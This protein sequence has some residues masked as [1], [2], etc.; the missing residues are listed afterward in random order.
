[1]I[2]S[3]RSSLIDFTDQYYILKNGLIID[4]FDNTKAMPLFQKGSYKIVHF[5]NETMTFAYEF[6]NN[7]D[8]QLQEV[9]I[10]E[11]NVSFTR[12]FHLNDG[13]QVSFLS[14]INS[15]QASEAHIQEKWHLL[16]QTNL[17]L[18]NLFIGQNVLSFDQRIMLEGENAQIKNKNVM[19]NA[20][21]TKQDFHFTIIH[22]QVHSVSNLQNYGICNRHS[23]LNIFT[24]GII[25]KEAKGSELKQKAKGLI[26]DEKS[27]IS[28]NPWLEINEHDCLASH[29]A[30]IGAI[31]DQ[32]LYY[33]MSRGLTKEQSE[34]LIIN[35]FIWPLISEVPSGK[36]RSYLMQWIDTHL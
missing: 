19:I 12:T 3:L 33:L 16:P 27:Q 24:D 30:S 7:A 29:G 9:V 18:N 26:L 36:L 15:N 23:L 22:E 25:N 8:V 35:G 17:N 34:K 14:F 13:S 10:V 4:S 5:V 31:D 11:N 32:E 21:N 28:A 1:M 2:E 6:A 20:S